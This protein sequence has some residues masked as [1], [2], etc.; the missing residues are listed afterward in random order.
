MLKRRAVD[1]QALRFFARHRAKFSIRLKAVTL[2]T[3]NTLM[4]VLGSKAFITL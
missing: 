4:S 1:G 2:V 3:L